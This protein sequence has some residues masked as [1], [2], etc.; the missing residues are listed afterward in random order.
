MQLL[1]A[2]SSHKAVNAF[3]HPRC[4][5]PV[6]SVCATI[7]AI[8]VATGGRVNI[9]DQSEISGNQA[10]AAPTA[11][12]ALGG[13][14]FVCGGSFLTI[15]DAQL[16]RNKAS[17]G[18]TAEGGFIFG[19]T[20]SFVEIHGSRL[21]DNVASTTGTKA[22]GGALALY[23]TL[24]V[25][26]SELKANVARGTDFSQGGGA[27]IYKGGTGFFSRVTCEANLANNGGQGNQGGAVHLFEGT[28]FVGLD[29][30]IIR[31]VAEGSEARGGGISS[32]A[33]SLQL[34][35]TAFESNR[36]TTT[37]GNGFGGGLFSDIGG[38]L[39]V[40]GASFY[41][42]IAEILD[43]SLSAL[44]A[45]GGAVFLGSNVKSAF[46]VGSH[47][48]ENYAGETP[49]GVRATGTIGT[50][51]LLQVASGPV[52]FQLHSSLKPQST[53]HWRRQPC[54]FLPP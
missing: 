27:A 28:S 44:R 4:V 25:F 48:G 46:I 5:V 3:L 50:W 36:A 23:G 16:N 30:Q 42:N 7:G 45:S 34:T 8:Y 18:G 31:N 37:K 11:T 39:N 41:G 14:L 12:S 15:A 54:T 43:N 26:S 24:R 32:L 47:F 49:S 1:A 19:R 40:E 22:I 17:G 9:S 35:S 29:L 51:S 2:L 53:L 6:P 38:Q 10:I 33:D 13:A 20:G 52:K 21:A